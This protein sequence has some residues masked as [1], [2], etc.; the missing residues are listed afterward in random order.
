MHKANLRIIEAAARR[1][2]IP[3]DRLVI[4]IDKFGNTSAASM[5]IALDE[6]YRDG[7]LQPGHNI[8]MVSFGAGFSLG[9]A[10]IRWSS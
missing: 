5:A 7:R 4:N 9:G 2:H 10:V 1:L 3:D 6:I 8:L